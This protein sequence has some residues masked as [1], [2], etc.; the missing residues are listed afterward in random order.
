MMG[1]KL[2]HVTKRGPWYFN[3]EVFFIN[4]CRCQEY[5][6]DWFPKANR[7]TGITEI[8]RFVTWPNNT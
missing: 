5:C 6:V 3:M 1:L 2:N 4:A 8:D 7:D